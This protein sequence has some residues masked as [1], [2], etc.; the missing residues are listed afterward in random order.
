MTAPV[1]SSAPRYRPDIDGLRALAILPVLFFHYQ[2]TLV[3]AQVKQR[4]LAN[5]L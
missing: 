4:E 5:L 2:A 3:F 1:P